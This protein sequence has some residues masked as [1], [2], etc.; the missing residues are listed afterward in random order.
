MA[1]DGGTMRRV[2]SLVRRALMKLAARILRVSRAHK[3]LHPRL[4]RQG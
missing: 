3:K 1:S 2:L 4:T